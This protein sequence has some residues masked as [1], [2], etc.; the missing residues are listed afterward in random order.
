M[1]DLPTYKRNS[2]TGSQEREEAVEPELRLRRRA[3]A[4]GLSAI[5]AALQLD[6]PV[7]ARSAERP[8][9]PPA[10]P[11]QRQQPRHSRQE[12]PPARPIRRSPDDPIRRS[13]YQAPEQRAEKHFLA[14]IVAIVSMVAVLVALA[15]AYW[16]LRR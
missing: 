8:P 5:Q 4:E 3:S 1:T 7:S 6:E 2:R 11:A 14:L 16:S 9:R 10:A 13:D 15:V 12:T